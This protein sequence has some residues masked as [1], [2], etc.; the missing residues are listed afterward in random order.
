M[1]N[2][3]WTLLGYTSMPLIFVFGFVLTALLAC[4]IMDML[5]IESEQA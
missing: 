5:G 3:I 4:M 1:E 2:M